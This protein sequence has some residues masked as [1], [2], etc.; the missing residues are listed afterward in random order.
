MLE[1][2]AFHNDQKIDYNAD[3][4][5]K[6]GEMTNICQYCKALKYGGE[7]T[8]WCCAGGKVKL[9]QLVPPADPLWSVVSGMGSDSKHF[10]A[11]MATCKNNH[12]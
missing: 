8:G 4:S 12:R 7:S 6:N 3:T 2:D 9:P 11:N 1:R 10:L 5:V